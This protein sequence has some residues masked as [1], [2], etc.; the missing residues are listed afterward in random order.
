MRFSTFLQLFDEIFRQLNIDEGGE[1]AGSGGLAVD[2]VSDGDKPHMV[3]PKYDLGKIADLQIISANSTHI[4]GQNTAD[5]PD[6]NV[7]NQPFPT[8]TVKIAPG[9]SIVRIM[10]AVCKALAGSVFL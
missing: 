7:R 10:D 8:R 4:L 9:P 1:L 5:F 6:L 3:L 2:A